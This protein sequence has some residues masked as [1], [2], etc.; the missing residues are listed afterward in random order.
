MKQAFFLMSVLPHAA[1]MRDAPITDNRKGNSQLLEQGNGPIQPQSFSSG[2]QE[3]GLSLATI[4]DS[5]L[6]LN[7]VLR[8]AY[9]NHSLNWRS[10]LATVPL[11]HLYE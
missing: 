4:C 5:F 2:A 10:V 8:D 7:N 1:P 3:F 9:P 6:E 11:A